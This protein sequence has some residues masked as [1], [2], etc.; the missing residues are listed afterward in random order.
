MASNP[1]GR[2]CTIGVKHEGDAKG[3]LTKIGK[4]E[5]IHL[6][7]M[8]YRVAD[9]ESFAVPAYITYPESKKTDIAILILP[10]VIGHEFINVQLYVHDRH[11]YMEPYG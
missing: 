6:R 11:R 4:S 8:A 2:C 1:P 5:W 10:D 7:I 9:I 3:E